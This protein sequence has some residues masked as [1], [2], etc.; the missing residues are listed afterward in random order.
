MASTK[1]QKRSNF[2]LFPIKNVSYF[3]TLNAQN[4]TS[5]MDFYHVLGYTFMLENKFY[6]RRSYKSNYL[7][8][9]RLLLCLYIPHLQVLRSDTHTSPPW[10]N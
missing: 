9:E 7:F 10:S 8:Q 3:E 5:D 1:G 4:S 2:Y 6:T